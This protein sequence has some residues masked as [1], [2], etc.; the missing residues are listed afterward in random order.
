MAD[1]VGVSAR[2]AGNN[3]MINTEERVRGGEDG[4][5][6]HQGGAVVLR[7]T[8]RGGTTSSR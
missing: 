4:T 5:L 3:P 1:P 8:R 6:V 7:T 2:V